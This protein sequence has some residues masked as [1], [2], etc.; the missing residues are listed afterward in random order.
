MQVNI[1]RIRTHIEAIARFT[2]TPGEGSTR[3]SY[4]PQFREA[5][6]YMRDKGQALGLAV[7]IDAVGNLRMRL[8]GADENA[9]AI[10]VGSHLDTVVNG[11]DFDGVLGVVCGL[12]VLTVLVESGFTPARPIELISFVEEEGISFRC[13][14]MGSKAATGQL[15]AEEL[16]ALR[17]DDG[18]SFIE[19]AKAFGLDPARVARDR[20]NPAD[21]RAMLE[22]HIE[23]GAV[24]ETEQLA[25]GVVDRIAGSEN[26]RVTLTG[27]ANHAGTTPMGLRRDA[28]CAAAEMISAIEAAGQAAQSPHTVATVGRIDCAPNAAN[29]IPGHVEFSIDI[30]DAH[31]TNIVAAAIAIRERIETIAARRE[32]G[33]EI[34][35][36]AKSAPQALAENIADRIASMAR[37][38]DIPHRRMH[39]G[40]LHD[41]AMMGRIADAGMI[42]V[43]SRSGISHSP[44]EWTDYADIE[45][46]ANVL[47]GVVV[48]LA[49][50]T[51]VEER[52]P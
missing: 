44:D 3:T 9:S 24:L 47:L 40:A 12:E 22:L 46:G 45:K 7:R 32:V 52:R 21:V 5:Y 2:A 18:K 35:L 25:V 31:E 15:T 28:L 19:A 50:D 10:V 39:S 13:P 36:T 23:Q 16:A 38:R 49:H 29:V 26:Y 14:L 41:T 34:E 43:P 30:R 1:D 51:P 11:G 42:F 48:E 8:S 33:C 4:S 27:R 37:A 17:T 20:I 6:D